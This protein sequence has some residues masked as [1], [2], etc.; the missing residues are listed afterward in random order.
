MGERVMHR[1]PDQDSVFESSECSLIHRRLSIIDLSEAGRQPMKT[2]DGRFVVAYNGEIYNYREL[3]KRYES[4]GWKFQS[5]TDTECFLASAALHGLRD[6]DQFHGIFAFALW[7]AKENRCYVARD[8]MGVKPLFVAVQ[9]DRVT[10]ASEIPAL[11][12]LK[13]KWK[14]D[15]VA[16]SMYLSVGYVQ[17]PRTIYEGIQSLE[18]GK[19]YEI[20]NGKL[21]D[22]GAF[23]HTTNVQS[24]LSRSEAKETLV[25]IVDKAVASQLV[26]DRPVGVFLSGGLDSSVVLSSMRLEQPNGA[27]KTFTTRFKHD[28]LDK[29][30]NRDAELAERTAKKYGC[31]HHETV[32][33][34]RIVID[35]SESIA[36]SLGQP[37]N[38]HSTV[39]LDAAAMLAK[40]DVAVVLSG[41]GGDESFGGYDRYKLYRRVRPLLTTSIGRALLRLHPRSRIWLNGLHSN[42]EAGA[43]FSFH[44]TSLFE[45]KELFGEAVNDDPIL[46]DWR[47]KLKDFSKMDGIGRFMALDRETW[48][49]DDAFVRSDRLTMRY[50]LEL[51]VPLTDDSI[52][53]FAESLPSDYHVTLNKTKALWRDAFAG[54]CLPE[55]AS[56]Q[57]R[58]WFPPTSK[59][60]RAGLKEW[61]RE[62]LED[63][64]DKH[65]WINGAVLRKIWDEHQTFKVYRLQEIWTV[66]SYHLWWLANRD[67]ISDV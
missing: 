67:K 39:A 57:K 12:H 51:R 30:F 31:D 38:N 32:I 6:L 4:E 53:E 64:I 25:R 1:G 27:I 61:S 20:L 45:R 16:R 44:V 47:K 54:R 14:I 10:F 35:S 36:R 26:S 13:D 29:K 41:D 55:I 8:R 43:M 56:E 50:G 60:L 7:D 62:I 18:P 59:W 37:H 5:R 15:T 17:G 21:C 42:D 28:T 63:A 33:D 40:K 2:S 58:G 65:P 52:V 3:R 11:L 23:Y 9:N 24:N 46:D 22:E 66:I 19:R 34:E 48:L 49:R